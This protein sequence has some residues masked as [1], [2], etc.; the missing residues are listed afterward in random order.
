MVLSCAT[1]TGY[2]GGMHDSIDVVTV[3]GG[4]SYQN[5]ENE[6]HIKFRSR[7]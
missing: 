6:I 7:E 3:T 2:S 5:G 4:V 1:T